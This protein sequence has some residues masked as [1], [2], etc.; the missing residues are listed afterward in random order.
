MRNPVLLYMG[1]FESE[2][3]LMLN[4]PRLAQHSRL[5]AAAQNAPPMRRGESGGPVK[6]LQQALVDLGA[7]MPGSFRG[8]DFDGIFG[9]ETER[10]LREF[11]LRRGLASDGV[12][13][14]QTFGTL[15][16]I[17]QTDDPFFSIP[18]VEHAK[19]IAQMLGPPE[20]R[21]FACTT[22]R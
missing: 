22:S 4:S 3:I 2:E 6:V 18:E 12:A 13:G 19:L 21:P 16:N 11:Q 15:D 1:V 8:G 5:L 7:H 10:V 20:M 17:F 9:P 14:Q